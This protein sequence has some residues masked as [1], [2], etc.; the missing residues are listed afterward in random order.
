MAQIRIGATASRRVLGSL[1]DLASLARFTIEEHPA[2]DLGT[3]RSLAET[4]CAPVNYETPGRS[5]WRC[6]VVCTPSP[7]GRLKV[8]ANAE[9][10]RRRAVR[11]DDAARRI[12]GWPSPCLCFAVGWGE[13]PGNP[14]RVTDASGFAGKYSTYAESDAA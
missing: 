14:C 9:P 6:C 11:N 5:L 4:P 3:W 10:I 12:A 2:I 1:N 13:G 7:G 8:G